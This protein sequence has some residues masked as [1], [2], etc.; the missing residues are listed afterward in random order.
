MNQSLYELTG[1][2]L[3]LFNML[4]DEDVNDD[5]IVD[6]CENLELRIEDK[7]DGYARI[8]KSIESNIAGIDDEMKRLRD[9]QS[10]LKNREKILKD[11]L[12]GAMRAI[13]KTKFKTDL[14]SFGIRKNPPSVK[15][16]D[17][18]AFIKRCQEDGHDDLLIFKEPTINKTA[19][20]NAV[21]KDGEII[22]GVEVVQTERLDIR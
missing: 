21:M 8:I 15:I 22:D 18:K 11:N 19:V 14:F 2:F 13:G 6:A 1:T 17:E 16:E 10:V 3:K 7:A 4:Y 9:R 20:K 5:F 12:E